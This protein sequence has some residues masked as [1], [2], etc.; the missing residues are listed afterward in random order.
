MSVP[1]L[2]DS[3]ARSPASSA[4]IEARGLA[5]SFGK[6][7]AL[8]GVDLMV[9]DH[10]VLG[11]LGPNG[12]GKTTLIR[13]LSTLLPPDRGSVHIAGFDVVR[14]PVA[15]RQVIGLAGQYAAVDEALS[16]RE[17]L[18]MIGR[19]YRLSAR[20]ARR[21]A[22]YALEKLSLTAAADRA[23]RT[24]SGGM[25]RRLDLGACLIGQPRVLLLDEPTTGLDPRARLDLWNFLR[26]QVSAGATIL[27]T[28]QQL[29]EADQL[30]DDIVVIDH[31]RVIAAD[32]PAALKARIGE[33]V[34]AVTLRDG[35]QLES[36]ASMLA[37]LVD[38]LPET[39]AESNQVSVRLR[40]GGVGLVD[41]VRSLD[42]ANIAIADIT[43]QRPSL[44]DVFFALTGNR[45]TTNTPTAS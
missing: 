39:D 3:D 44:D 4:V 21:R 12:A 17:N 43:I 30:A 42:E 9:R 28:T 22:Q 1:A 27:L 19:L 36:A 5:K 2:R 29:E 13:I 14:Q 25:R 15:V 40:A 45:S 11:L 31:G 37:G 33:D 35:R 41:I 23:V 24:Y 18:E 26:E 8:D 10:R 7:V 6:T 20:E 34:V 38:A 32:T 16:G